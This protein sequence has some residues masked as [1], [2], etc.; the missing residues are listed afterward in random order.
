MPRPGLAPDPTAGSFG[1]RGS[2]EGMERIPFSLPF[3]SAE[4]GSFRVLLRKGMRSTLFPH[5]SQSV[6]LSVCVESLE[7]QP[8]SWLPHHLSESGSSPSCLP[9]HSGEPHTHSPD[10]GTQAH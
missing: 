1:G 7:I 6:C 2:R 8:P 9:L 4:F 5:R 3:P 10:Q